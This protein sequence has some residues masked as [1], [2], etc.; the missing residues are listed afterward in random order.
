MFHKELPGPAAGKPCRP[1]PGHFFFGKGLTPGK[2]RVFRPGNGRQ[3]KDCIMQS[4][5]K[6]ASHRHRKHQSRKGQKDIRDPHEKGIQKAAAP[7][8]E[9]PDSCPDYRDHCNQKKCRKHAGLTSGDHP[10]KHISAVTI[11]AKKM[12]GTG[13]CLGIA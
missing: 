12:Q 7:A 13:R 9:D 5:A 1:H 3:S 4:S 10:G 11:R 6:A 8:A 2:P